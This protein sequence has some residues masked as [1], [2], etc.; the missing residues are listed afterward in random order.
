[1]NLVNSYNPYSNYN[2]TPNISVENGA[3]N[4]YTVI[5]FKLNGAHKSYSSLVAS[6]EN[7]YISIS[8]GPAFSGFILSK[9][10]SLAILNKQVA[11]IK[12]SNPYA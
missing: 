4:N 2:F 5:L 1:M 10:Q 8:T 3:H 11:L 9:E 12:G 6:Y 7:F